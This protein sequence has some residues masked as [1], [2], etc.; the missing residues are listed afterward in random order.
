M[1]ICRNQEKRKYGSYQDSL[2]NS[3]VIHL[4]S[5]PLI[6]FSV[7]SVPYILCFGQPDCWTG[8]GRD[9][10]RLFQHLYP[11][12]SFT[13]YW[14]LIDN[15]SGPSKLVQILAVPTHPVILQVCIDKQ[16]QKDLVQ[17]CNEISVCVHIRN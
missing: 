13:Q 7:P 1:R 5:N 8:I 15:E 3:Y 14:G 17:L 2:T 16:E 9:F 10:A 6:P 11:I 12:E 4:L